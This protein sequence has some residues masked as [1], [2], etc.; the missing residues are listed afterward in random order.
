MVKDF[1]R[2][3]GP[4]TRTLKGHPGQLSMIW[5]AKLILSNLAVEVSNQSTLAVKFEHR[6]LRLLAHHSTT[7][8]HP[9]FPNSR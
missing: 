2:N 8:L 4:T 3:T 7:E 5:L 6:F 9:Y 1:Y